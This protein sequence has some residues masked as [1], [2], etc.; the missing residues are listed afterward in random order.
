MGKLL[1]GVKIF[2]RKHCFFCAENQLVP[3]VLFFDI[4]FFLCVWSLFMWLYNL[5]RQR[6]NGNRTK[7][8]LVLALPDRLF[9]CVQ[10]KIHL[11]SHHAEDK[12][13]Q[14]AFSCTLSTLCSEGTQFHYQTPPHV[15]FALLFGLLIGRR[16]R[17]LRGYITTSWPGERPP[18]PDSRHRG[19][20]VEEFILKCLWCVWRCSISLALKAQILTHR[21]NGPAEKKITVHIFEFAF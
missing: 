3:F 18:S 21:L 9:T 15:P 4:I 13:R 1:P 20:N 16:V 5:K 10:I 14:V 19:F 11:L 7:I 6:R 17:M 2:F 8:V 12:R